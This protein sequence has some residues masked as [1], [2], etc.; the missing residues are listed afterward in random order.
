MVGGYADSH[1][2]HVNVDDLDMIQTY[3]HYHLLVRL[4]GLQRSDLLV[5][6]VQLLVSADR[7]LQSNSE[8][9]PPL[10][11]RVRRIPHLPH[12]L[13]LRLHLRQTHRHPVRHPVRQVSA[14]HSSHSIVVGLLEGVESCDRL[15]VCEQSSAPLQS[16]EL[17]VRV[18]ARDS[19][20]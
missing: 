8:V 10:H 2:F 1:S 9:H 6:V 12:L 16:P 20:H 5:V 19:W 14:D 18:R 3:H 13:L 11:L 15:V 7:F 17:N 4:L